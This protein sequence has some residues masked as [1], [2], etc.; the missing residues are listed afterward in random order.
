MI[1]KLKYRW[2]HQPLACIILA[3]LIF[4]LIAVV[5]SKGFG[6]FDDHFL[7]V[8]QAQCWIDRVNLN[9][10]LPQLSDH[11]SPP[12]YSYFYTALHYLLFTALEKI[13]M[14]DP[15]GKMYVV[16]L[17]HAL[18]SLLTIYF[19][20][21]IT[22]KLAGRATAK[23]VGLLLS[24]FWFWPFLSVRNLIEVAC[25]P[26]LMWATWLA[27]KNENGTFTGYI[28]VGVLLGL[29]FNIRFQTLFFSAGFVLT[30][31]LQKKLLPAIACSLG[32][33]LCAAVFQGGIDW[34]I[35]HVPFIE[36]KG[37]ILYNLKNAGAF[38][39]LPWFTYIL[40]FAGILIP[41]VSLFFITGFFSA[42]KKHLLLFLPS[43]IFLLFHSWFPNKQERFILP[44]LPFIIMLG[45]IG[46]NELMERKGYDVKFQKPIRYMWRWFFVLNTILLFVISFTY[47]KRNRV[48][49]MTYLCKKGDVQNLI[50][51]NSNSSDEMRSPRFYSRKWPYEYQVTD[52]TNV[53]GLCRD[54]K[55]SPPANK[56][57][58]I[59][60]YESD[61][62]PQRLAHLQR[63]YELRHEATIDP[64][65]IDDVV[66]R[67]NPVNVNSVTYIYKI[68]REK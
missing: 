1:E 49:A 54:L 58:Y 57:N 44:L 60:F 62:L 31:L 56:P 6:M 5:F 17:L 65:F 26:M 20:Y 8:E 27:I 32:I 3:G 52:K 29:A 50:I 51:E 40:L 37:Y 61:N 42:Y 66:H 2:Q 15:Q 14:Y 9:D 7:I 64:S 19:G 68:V 13:G 55:V 36:F 28:A 11:A 38:I 18:Y 23:Q 59:L 47:S 34:Y 39:V 24:L 25:I 45:I 21:R 63:F 46:W 67:L 12:G 43:F 4:R 35:W 53:D 22:E 10:W 48:E 33:V 30:L 16:R 41:P